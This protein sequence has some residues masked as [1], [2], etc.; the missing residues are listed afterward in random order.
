MIKNILIFALFLV[1]VLSYCKPESVSRIH[2]PEPESNAGVIE[3]DTVN[4]V[5]YKIPVVNKG[6]GTLDIHS[7][8]S[9]CSCLKITEADSIVNPGDT[10]TITAE[11]TITDAKSYGRGFYVIHIES[12]DPDNRF[13]AAHI[14]LL[15]HPPVF[16]ELK[17]GQPDKDS[18][19]VAVTSRKNDL[20]LMN[21]DFA[22]IGQTDTFDTIR[23]IPFDWRQTGAVDTNGYRHYDLTIFIRHSELIDGEFLITT[24]HP[25]DTLILLKG[26]MGRLEIQDDSTIEKSSG[27]G[28]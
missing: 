26:W 19:Q 12:S 27:A 22:Y 15:L 7:I 6:T 28:K 8:K 16:A 23:G 10:G 13:V 21:V 14:S 11:L 4:R 9:S 18:M 20:Q 1:C 17:P 3:K 24:N 5:M 25:H 2:L